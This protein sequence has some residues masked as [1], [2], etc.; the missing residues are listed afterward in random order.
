M[1]ISEAELNAAQL[2]GELLLLALLSKNEIAPAL[3]MEHV[4]HA[5]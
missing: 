5:L 4:H 3:Y 2:F 1:S